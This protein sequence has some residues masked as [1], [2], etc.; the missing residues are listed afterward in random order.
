MASK[1]IPPNEYTMNVLV[2]A[3]GRVKQPL[4]ATKLVEQMEADL[5]GACKQHSS[6]DTS[7]ARVSIY[8]LIKKCLWPCR[9]EAEHHDVQQPP[10]GVCQGR[11]HRR[12]IR[13]MAGAVQAGPCGS[14]AC[15]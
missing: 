5:G 7:H 4:R 6:F 10:V 11:G 15:A 1:G 14:S 3:C 9:S 2:S 12:R 13:R 8:V